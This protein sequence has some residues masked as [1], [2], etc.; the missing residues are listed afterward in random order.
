MMRIL[1][2][3]YHYQLKIHFSSK[4]NTS[5]MQPSLFVSLYGTKGDAEDLELRL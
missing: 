2:A 4:V 3:V 1:S 5:D